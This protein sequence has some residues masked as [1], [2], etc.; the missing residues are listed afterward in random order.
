[1]QFI[2]AGTGNEWRIFGQILGQR[3][4]AD[5][6]EYGKRADVSKRQKYASPIP[7]A[8]ITNE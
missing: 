7:Q 2:Q 6:T 1:M 3:I 4:T 8:L 5:K